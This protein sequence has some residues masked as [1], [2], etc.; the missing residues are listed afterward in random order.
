VLG[1]R[2]GIAVD[3]Q[4]ATT[5]H[6]SSLYP[7]HADAGFGEAGVLM[8][9][10]I[11]AGMAGFYFDPFT[12]Y[13]THLTNPNLIICGDVGSGKSAT[14]KSLLR[15]SRAVYGP[16]RHLA[17]IDPKGEY[18]AIAADLALATI[19]LHPGGAQQ[20]NPLDVA[21][22]ELGDAVLA[23]QQLVAQLIT[24]VLGRT[25]TPLEDAVLGWAIEQCSRNRISFTLRD[26]AGAIATPGD[27][28]VRLARQSPLELA[29]ATSPVT[30]AI[31]KLC[32]RTLRGMFDQPSNV[33]I[34]W[35]DGPGVVI[36]LSAVYDNRDA[37][38][39][40]VLA[41]TFWL[42]QA[43]RTQPTRPALQAIDEA[44]AAVRY[45][46]EYFQ[47]SLK[48]ART[49]GVATILVV[50][51][52]AD[53]VAQTDDGTTQAKIAA[54]LLAD[55][56]TRVLLRQPPDQIEPASRLFELTERERH[57]LGHL[58]RGRAVWRIKD[59]SAVVQNI[60]TRGELALFDTDTAMTTGR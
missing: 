18:G 16:N 21:S 3:W 47:S 39:L 40:V 23:R 36:D 41:A 29:R 35:A 37:L 38:P 33:T 1:A 10:N 8:G 14:V 26:L 48:L 31:D 30:F 54:G 46:A 20:V 24:G 56:Q 44:W 28:L 45:G 42:S 52:P 4:R 19:K 2:H 51:K 57:W 17:I 34:D 5:A 25:L 27:E 6:L 7:F 15:R 49:H 60:L 32:T 43:L 12:F 13:G 22:G 11:T 55:I 50:H 9:A 59:R 53:L 58:V